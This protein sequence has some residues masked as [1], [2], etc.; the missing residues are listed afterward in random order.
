MYANDHSIA[1]EPFV[2]LYQ[3]QYKREMVSPIEWTSQE[4][5]LGIYILID[6]TYLRSL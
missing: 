3:V 2:T 4:Q 6:M 5:R 1:T